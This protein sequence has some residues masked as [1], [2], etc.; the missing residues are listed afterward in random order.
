MAQVRSVCEAAIKYFGEDN[1]KIKAIE[2]LSELSTVMARD[3]NNTHVTQDEIVDK[4]ADGYIMIQ[5]LSVMY[6]EGNVLKR[7]FEK[8]DRMADMIGTDI[9]VAK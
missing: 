1:Q 7:V 5:Q 4:I 6:G 2:E 3:I 8:T 9:G